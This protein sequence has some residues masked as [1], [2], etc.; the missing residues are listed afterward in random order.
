MRKMK[1][2]LAV[3]L[4]ATMVLGSA[5]TVLAAPAGTGSTTGAGASEGHVNKEVLNMVLPTVAAG[6]SPFAYTMDPER[7]IQE[8]GGA[9]Y[10]DYTFPAAA[11]DTGVYFLTGDKTYANESSTLQAVNKSS[12]NVT[13]TVKVKATASAGGKDIPLVSAASTSTS[14]AELYLGLKVGSSTQA[15]STTEATV[16]K[17]VA[18]TPGNFET[19]VKD[20]EGGAQG[21]KEYVYQEKEDATTWKAMNISMTGN[22]NNYKI[23]ADTTAPT[24]EVT[25]EYDKAAESA[26][27]DT[28]D[29]TDYT[30][31]PPTPATSSAASI[32]VPE[33]GNATVA[34]TVGDDGAVPTSIT[35]DWFEGNLL[36]IDNGWGATYDV[37]SNT[38]TFDTGV[39]DAMRSDKTHTF[40]LTFTPAEE[41]GSTY[42]QNL[43]FAQ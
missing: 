32:V 34:V 8:T 13:L 33:S 26:T 39:S 27:P 20:K 15:V 24:V 18:G 22:V 37:D 6:T 42:T 7:L 2:G 19:T 17:T 23:D 1:Q 4:A 28:A 3:A 5:F 25:W 30:T 31:T 40:T 43:T 38:I 21:E 29:Q 14:A 35:T 10:E 36:T 12:C 41:G 11:S 9:K 16:T